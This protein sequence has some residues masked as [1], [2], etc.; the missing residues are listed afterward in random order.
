MSNKPYDPKE[1]LEIELE[2]PVLN[3][4]VATDNA[5]YKIKPG[6]SRLEVL[7]EH[8]NLFE[9]MVE[10]DL[11]VLTRAQK[12]YDRKKV[13]AVQKVK[14]DENGLP[15]N[16]DLQKALLLGFKYDNSPQK[17]FRAEMGRDVKPILS[18]KIVGSK[19]VQESP[20]EKATKK[21]Q[22]DAIALVI[23]AMEQNKSKDKK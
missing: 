5:T 13:E 22:V 9:K 6:K 21:A 12:V 15:Q 11:D 7:A 10:P 8:L 23:E 3:L 14:T 18:L 20:A 19:G 2:T 17:I 1:L 16:P 4:V